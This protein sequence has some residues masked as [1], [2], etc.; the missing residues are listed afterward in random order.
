MSLPGTC[1]QYTACVWFLI[2]INF[3]SNLIIWDVAIVELQM[4][5]LQDV[6]AMADAAAADVIG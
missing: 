1:L 5:N 6:K 2:S 3:Q 4:G